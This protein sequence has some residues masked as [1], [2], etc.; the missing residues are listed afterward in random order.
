[1]LSL[2]YERLNEIVK[3]AAPFRGTTNRYPLANRNHNLKHFFVRQ[4]DGHDVYDI[5]NGWS[6]KMVY[7]DKEAKASYN[8]KV[9]SYLDYDTNKTV[10]YV[11]DIEPNIVGTV[12]PDNCLEIF[13]DKDTGYAYSDRHFL[14]FFD[15]TGCVMSDSRRG[16]ILYTSLRRKIK[17]PLFNGLKM[18]CTGHTL[19]V[20]DLQVYSKVLNRKN[21]AELLG[22]YETFFKRT[23]AVLKS[24][25]YESHLN[26]ITDVVKERVGNTEN[27]SISRETCDS[28]LKEGMSIIKDAPLDA[29]ALLAIAQIPS[30]KRWAEYS[31]TSAHRAGY[32]RIST[33]DAYATFC[34]TFK[35]YLYTQNQDVF[36]LKEHSP[37]YPMPSSTWGYMIIYNGQEVYQL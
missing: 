6:S 13:S 20:G 27:T 35:K 4:E 28:F 23:E 32:W 25:D 31:W 18:S 12:K 16:G 22:T 19:P 5:A 26:L 17:F 30:I 15:Q 36:K 29:Y 34:K 24:L 8:K 2:A 21:C 10:Y 14:S 33:E 1:M 7:V 9:H 3:T 37:D 11:F